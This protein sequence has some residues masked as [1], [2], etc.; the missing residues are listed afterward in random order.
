MTSIQGFGK[1]D[2][3]P[4]ILMTNKYMALQANLRVF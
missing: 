3:I 4:T 2:D 1:L